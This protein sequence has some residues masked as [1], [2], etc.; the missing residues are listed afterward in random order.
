MNQLR[1]VALKGA[2]TVARLMADA[3]L[4]AEGRRACRA[5]SSRLYWALFKIRMQQATQVMASM[6]LA[7]EGATVAMTRLNTSLGSLL[8]RAT[9]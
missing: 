5:V 2:A 6:S 7:A 8:R 3:M 9:P 4:T 1:I